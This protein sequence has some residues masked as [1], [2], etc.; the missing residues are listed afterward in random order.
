MDDEYLKPGTQILWFPGDDDENHTPCE[1]V[2][3]DDEAFLVRGPTGKIF[4]GTTGG[5][6][7]PVLT[8]KVTPL[9]DLF[10]A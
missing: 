5:Y 4:D 6:M 7:L 10:G 2:Q 3:D 1:V 8:V 9:S